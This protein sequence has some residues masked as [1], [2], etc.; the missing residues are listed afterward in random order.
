MI[1]ELNSSHAYIQSGDFDVPDRPK[2]A[3]PGARFAADP[4][5]GRYKIAR[6]LTGEND[7]DRY[8]APLTEVGVDARVGDYLIAIDG[9][10]VKTTDNP[11]RLLRNKADRPVEL[12]LNDHAVA[13]GA[14][15][16]SFK[17]VDSEENLF[18]LA[19]VAGNC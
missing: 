9:E 4:A 2:V 17:P 16:V 10:E 19:W 12:T 1:S 15:K 3:L 7:E 8:R 6:I 5:A 18:Y 11:Y 13:D 14:R